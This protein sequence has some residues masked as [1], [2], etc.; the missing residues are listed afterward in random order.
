MRQRYHQVY[1]FCLLAVLALSM[2]SCLG[3]GGNTG[4]NS[5]TNFKQA[6]TTSNGTSIGVNT[7]D[8]AIFKG[9]IYF[10]LDR[11]L[12]VLDG[13]RNIKQ[14]T[15]G[16]DVRDP[17]VSP[18][19]KWIAFIVRHDDKNYSD[20]VY[21]PTSGGP[22][23]I[24]CTGAG[25]YINNPPYPAP[26]ST[27]AWYA[28]P[29]WAPDSTH[30]LFLSD[31][32]K[33]Q[34]NPGVDAF[35]L[36]LMVFS[37]SIHDSCPSQARNV[38]FA[39]YGDGGDRDPSYRPHH[40]EVVYTHFAYDSSQTKQVIQILLTNPDTIA[41]HPQMGYKPGVYEFDPAVALTP[42]TPDLTNM[43][44]TF[45]PDGNSL[46]Y[47]RRQDATH[48]ALYIMRVPDG[49]TNGLKPTADIAQKALAPY[50]QSSLI[51]TSLYVSQPIWSPDG[52]QIA[53][54]NYT[55]NVFNIWL[56]NLSVN[57]KTGLYT[58]SN[59]STPVQLTDAGGHLNADSR[60]FWTP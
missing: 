34:W 49:L 7:S 35:L 11:N 2:Q 4:I 21:M 9:K 10:T 45:S 8:Q 19:G 3:I 60:P 18:D 37:I 48:M 56:V 27:S 39:S 58:M 29:A 43:E 12:Y 57:A 15:H 28:Q 42:P 53:Y 44:P 22:V 25:R 6:T 26:K 16:M 20:L 33:E 41:T 51:L 47:I 32:Q 13:N 5:S 23:K 54:L 50:Q 55:N 30:L 40:N 46:A 36:D 31:F 38:A 14:L 1:V 17:A 24:L 59:N 52:K